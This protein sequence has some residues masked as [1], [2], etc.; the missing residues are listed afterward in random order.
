[1]S[2]GV[3]IEIHA[4]RGLGPVLQKDLFYFGFRL[5]FVTLSICRVCVIDS[6]K[7]LRESIEARISAD[8]KKLRGDE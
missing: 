5:G 4:W 6:Y 2:P 1:M 3:S 8:E 7:M